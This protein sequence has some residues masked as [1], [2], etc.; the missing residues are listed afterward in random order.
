MT[1]TPL[2]RGR[3][4]AGLLLVMQALAGCLS[5]AGPEVPTITDQPKD[6]IG[7]L[8]ATVRFDVGVSG[9][10]PMTFQWLRNGQAIE[11]ATGIAYQTPFLTAAD[12]GAK[13]SV[14][15]SNAEGSV[16]SSEATVKVN[17]PPAVT[18]QPAP[19]TVSTGASASFTVAASGESLSYQWLRD[20]VPIAGANAATYTISTTSAADDG[21]VFRAFVVNPAG[22]VVSNTAALTVSGAPAVTVQP[23]GQTVAAGE[24]ALFSV[25]ATGGNLAYQWQRNG[26]DIAGATAATYRIPA[27]AAGD[28]N[29]SFT[30]RM[31]NAQ[32]NVTSAAAVLRVTAAAVAP[33]PALVAEV[34][35]SRNT[36]NAN[37]FTLVRR[38]NGSIAGWGYNVEGQLGNGTPGP[39]S[40]SI[41]QAVLPAGRRATAVAA[42]FNHG[43]ALLDNGDVLAWGL[44]DTGQ[45]GLGDGTPRASPAKVTLPG[46]AIAVAAGRGFSVVALADGRVFTWGGN[47]IGQLGDGSRNTAVS[48]VRAAGLTGIVAVAAGTS[49]ALALGSDG[50]V[51][52]WGSNLSGQL[53]DGTFK[54]ALTPV[55]TDLTEIVRIRAGGDHSAAV[56]RRR[57]LYLW[58]EN[59]DGQL[60]LGA[61]APAD[62]GV[63]AGAAQA[64]VDAAPGSRMTLLVGSDGL[65]RSAGANDAGSLGDGGTTARN[66]FGA[67][68][69]VSAGITVGAG[70]LSF[71]AAIADNGTTFMWGD[72]GSKQLGNTTIAATGTATPTAVPN[73]DAIP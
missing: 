9:K 62:L 38:S 13:F 51:W 54:P 57:T 56:S 73:F 66:T 7:F 61:G 4:L 42:G 55:P 21:A 71:A 39:A 43:L 12:D 33:L 45:L 14:R 20:E 8:G 40:D 50:R 47:T 46:P 11:G 26:A 22:F 72:N 35:L 49:H 68:S 37:S 19:V 44:N 2:R 69:A 60:G 10:P 67:V 28:D 34:S 64:V 29:A 17:G 27:A 65:A 58:G 6:R 24:P 32:G 36:S 25:R 15:I 63:P 48:P 52:A 31:T 59:A 16:T 23:V 30:V 18:T 3:L 70:G 5:G 41:V 1:H 53:G